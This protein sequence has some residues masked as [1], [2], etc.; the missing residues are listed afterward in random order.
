ME[1]G[2]VVDRPRV[3]RLIRRVLWDRRGGVGVLVGY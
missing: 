2:F 3:S 1:C